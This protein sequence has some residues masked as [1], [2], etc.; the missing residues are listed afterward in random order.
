MWP[1]RVHD[2]TCV[3]SSTAL[4]QVTITVCTSCVCVCVSVYVLCVCEYVCFSPGFRASRIARLFP[5][6]YLSCQTG[7]CIFALLFS[8]F[9][10]HVLSSFLSIGFSVSC[11]FNC[12]RSGAHPFLG[13]MLDYASEHADYRTAENEVLF[14]F[15]EFSVAERR[16]I[17]CSNV[18]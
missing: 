8:C 7:S 11:T 16:P 12:S 18:I 3:W 2:A 15:Y 4:R 17:L 5:Q 1:L 14:A 6:A 9:T 13:R 10:L